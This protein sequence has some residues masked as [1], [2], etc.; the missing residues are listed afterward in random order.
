MK[1]VFI[2]GAGSGIGLATTK[3]LVEKGYFVIASVRSFKRSKELLA[4]KK[5]TVDVVEM[6]V[7]DDIQ[8]KDVAKY[9]ETCYGKVDILINN[10][11]YSQGGFLEYLSM[12]DWHRQFETNL[13][14]TVR[15]TKTFLP[16]IRK[17]ERGRIINVSSISG[18]FGFPGLAP[19]TSS[20]FAL[21]GLSE[22]LRFELKKEEIFVSVVQPASFRTGIWKKG[23]ETVPQMKNPLPYQ[24]QLLQEGTKSMERGQHPSEV[25]KVIWKICESPRPHFRYRVGKGAKPLAF[26]KTYLPWWLLE[27]IVHK[28]TEG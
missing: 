15:V 13:F 17:S 3:W 10:A 12:D 20:K 9:V 5:E 25:A 26:F 8:V 14:G 7:T 18:F 21:E 28:K 24:K 22:S 4:L 1:I 23:I 11:G 19:Y 27:R 2:T 16:L 6:D